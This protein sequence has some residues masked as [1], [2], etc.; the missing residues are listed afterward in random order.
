MNGYTQIEIGGK[1]IGIKFGLPALEMLVKKV[2]EYTSLIDEKGN[3]SSA[4]LAYM[5]YYG[6]LNN[7][8]VKEVSPV[9]KF[10]FFMDH[11]E[12]VAHD[13]EKAGPLATVVETWATS[14][15]VVR[16]QDAGKKIS[17]RKLQTV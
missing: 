14:R 17:K 5:I 4:G 1:A 2:N 6:Y 10:E 12:S 16:M 3:F 13:T 9:H 11:I 15:E 8:M 7:C